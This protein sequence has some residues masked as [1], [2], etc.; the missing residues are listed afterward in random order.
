MWME[1]C[2]GLGL[3]MSQDSCRDTSS[4]YSFFLN[5]SQMGTF[6]N[7]QTYLQ[8]YIML[9]PY[10]HHIPHLDLDRLLH[11]KI[12]SGHARGRSSITLRIQT[13]GS[14]GKGSKTLDGM[15]SNKF[16]LKCLFSE[17]ISTLA[18]DIWR[19]YLMFERKENMFKAKQ[20]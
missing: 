12:Q 14:L 16:S 8:G 18:A 4:E 2:H 9:H 7:I 5:P 6:L 13:D 20:H 15:T 19:R 1:T 11:P 10:L 17:T 3:L